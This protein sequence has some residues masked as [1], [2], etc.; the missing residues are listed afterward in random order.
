MDEKAGAAANCMCQHKRHYRSLSCTCWCSALLCSS[1]TTMDSSRCCFA[2]EAVSHS[3]HLQGASVFMS[4]LGCSLHCS[5]TV[6]AAQRVLSVSPFLLCYSAPLRP[7]P[8]CA[9]CPSAPPAC[10]PILCLL[11]LFV[12]GCLPPST[13]LPVLCC[14]MRQTWRAHL[15]PLTSLSPP[16]TLNYCQSSAGWSTTL[17]SLTQPLH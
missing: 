2:R 3:L 16:P 17:P 13:F 1:C 7:L 10:S 12:T 5:V 8:L 6:V 11:P 14:V 15:T 4:P 9:P